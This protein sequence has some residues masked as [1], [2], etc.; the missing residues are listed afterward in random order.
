MDALTR[1]HRMRGAS[2]AVAAGHRPRRHRHADGG[3]APAQC[4]G[5]AAQRPV[6][7]SIRRARLG[8]E[9]AVGRHHR[10]ARCGA[11]APRSTGR[12]S[13]SRMDPGLSRAVLE[14]FVRLHEQGLIYRGQR[15]VNW[16]PVLRTA[17]SDLEVLSR[18]GSRPR[19]GICAIRCERRHAA[20]SWSRPPA[21]E[22]MLG[23]AAVAV[24][25]DDE[26]YRALIGRA[27]AAAAR[28]ARRFRSSPTSYVD[29]SLRHRLREDHAGARLQRLRHRPA[30][31]PAA[32]QHLH[33]RCATSTSTRRRICAAW[34]ASRPASASCRN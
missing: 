23:D 14:A 13:A 30:A 28:R 5:Q 7:R 19:S 1:R 27:R 11:S 8:L 26:R 20:M 17:L 16:D 2:D 31:R 18:G 32:D 24:N 12:A 9:G 15:L 21:P 25:P 4:R 33:A 3:R 6:A 10:H 22:T 34:I 29:P